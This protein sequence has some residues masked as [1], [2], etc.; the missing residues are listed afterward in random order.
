[1]A[2]STK[3]ETRAYA[4]GRSDERHVGKL[5]ALGQGYGANMGV[6]TPRSNARFRSFCERY[7]VTRSEFFRQDPEGLAEDTWSCI[8]DAKR[9]YSLIRRTSI[10]L[11]EDD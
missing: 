4:K 6:E 5:R 9:A 8:L 3:E 2:F 7:V 10:G 11:G 1:M